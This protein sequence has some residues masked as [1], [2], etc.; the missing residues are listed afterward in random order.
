MGAISSVNPGLSAVLQVVATVRASLAST[1]AAAGPG[2]DIVALSVAAA[3]LASV[4]GILGGSAGAAVDGSSSIGSI[5][6]M[7]G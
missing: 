3:Q 4:Q 5:V 7:M 6:N 1:P 2:A